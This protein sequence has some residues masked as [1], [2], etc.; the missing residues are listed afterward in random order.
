MS[1]SSASSGNFEYRSYPTISTGHGNNLSMIFDL[2]EHYRAA[3][4]GA[5]AGAARMRHLRVLVGGLTPRTPC[6]ATPPPAPSSCLRR[7]GD[8]VR[9]L[10]GAA[11]RAAGGGA[12]PRVRGDG[13]GRGPAPAAPLRPAR[14]ADQRRIVTP[15]RGTAPCPL[16]RA[17]SRTSPGRRGPFRPYGGY[18]YGSWAG[19]GVR[20]SPSRSGRRARGDL[21]RAISL[22]GSLEQ[23]H[24]D[25]LP[26]DRH[27]LPR[28]QPLVA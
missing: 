19:T 18:W 3:T 15:G 20:C 14:L 11:G 6:G 5:Y 8:G 4:G 9:R 21:S 26:L 23:V 1:R 27:A 7:G 22:L 25:D 17:G 24:T 13:E 2:C 12:D 28:R 16:N 10:R